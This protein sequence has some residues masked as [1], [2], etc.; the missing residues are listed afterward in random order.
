MSISTGGVVPEGADAVVPVEYVVQHDNSIEI[1]EAIAPGAHVRP[2]GGDVAAG[3]VVVETGVRL[4]AAQLGAP[5]GCRRCRVGLRPR[6]TRRRPVDGH[7]ARPS[8][9]AASRGPGLRGERRHARGSGRRRRRRDRDP[10]GGRRRRVGAPGGARTRSRRGRPRHVGR[11]LGRRRTISCAG[12]SPSSVS[13]RSSGA[14]RSSRASRCRS[15]CAARRSCSGCR[16]TR[17][18]RSSAASCSSSPRFARCRGVQTP[19][20]R[21]ERGTLAAPLQQERRPR[22]ARAG[23]LTPGPRRNGARAAVR[24]GVAH[25]RARRRR[26]RARP[27][28]ARRRR[29]ARGRRRALASPRRRLTLSPRSRAV[30]PR[31]RGAVCAARGRLCRIVS[32]IGPRRPSLRGARVRR[33]ATARERDELPGRGEPSRV[34]SRA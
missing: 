33:V 3:D 26:R 12:S 4:G 30:P 27:R 6:A 8:G 15:A 16:G 2:R 7:G 29:A 14:L 31:R 34:R 13:R 9:A 21:F 23:A 19:L 17:C 5:R 32:R 1:A 24:P 28:A 20:P 11:S 22:R 10:A 25:D 18:R